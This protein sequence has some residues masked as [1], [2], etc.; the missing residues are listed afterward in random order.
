MTELE[1][2]GARLAQLRREK[3]ARDRTDIDAKVVAKAVKT[4]AAS[5]SRYEAGLVM[6]RE[7]VFGR[8]CAYY[9]VTRSWLRYEEGER[10]PSDDEGVRLLTEAARKGMEAP[11]ATSTARRRV[12]GKKSSG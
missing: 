3:A 12:G 5:Y 10:F 2:L 7:D 9:G 11:P 8:L 4:S 6:P 1:R